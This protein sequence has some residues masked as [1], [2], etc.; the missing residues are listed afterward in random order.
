MHGFYV[1]HLGSQRRYGSVLATEP[2]RCRRSL[3]AQKTTIPLPAA[4]FALG[5]FLLH[6]RIGP[7]TSELTQKLFCY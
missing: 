3:D 2:P 7:V 1:I 4:L 6:Y 5:V